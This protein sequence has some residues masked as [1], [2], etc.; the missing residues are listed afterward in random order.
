MKNKEQGILHK[1]FYYRMTFNWFWSQISTP[2]AIIDKILLIMVWFKTFNVFPSPIVYIAAFSL[3]VFMMFLTDM[4][5]KKGALTRE[6]GI[7]ASYNPYATE[8][9][10]RLKRIEEYLTKVK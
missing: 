9:I 8:T 2:M 10:E 3:L 6:Q 1:Y 4:A 7:N 5:I